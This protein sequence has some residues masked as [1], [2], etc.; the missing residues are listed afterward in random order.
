MDR[1]TYLANMSSTQHSTGVENKHDFGG[2]WCF[3]LGWWAG[4]GGKWVL[5]WQ[6]WDEAGLMKGLTNF[7][8]RDLALSLQQTGTMRWFLRRNDSIHIE[9]SRAQYKSKMTWNVL[10]SKERASGIAEVRILCG[11][12]QAPSHHGPLGHQGNR[13]WLHTKE[14][15]YFL[16]LHPPIKYLLSAS[17]TEGNK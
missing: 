16:S 9:G 10:T 13:K 1:Q 7:R 4:V 2:Q 6:G 12:L 11:E 5:W 15:P 3:R 8:L 17:P 14:R